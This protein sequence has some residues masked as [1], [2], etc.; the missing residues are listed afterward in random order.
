MLQDYFR[1]Y[2]NLAIF[3]G[4]AVAVPLGMLGLSFI[5]TWA[6][7]RPQRP[8]RV[9]QASY[10]SGLPPMSPRPVLFSIRYYQYAL[11]FVVFDVETVFLY[12]WAVKFGVLSKQFGLVA[13]AAV[14]VFLAVLTVPYVYAWRK[15]ALEWQ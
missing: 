12:P 15:K 4:L 3:I 8:G 2:G 13:L 7:V 6:K 1:H 10:E 9:K 11:L 14:L 5:A